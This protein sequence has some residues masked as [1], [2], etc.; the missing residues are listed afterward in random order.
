MIETLQDTVKMDPTDVMC[1]RCRAVEG[2]ACTNAKG[3]PTSRSHSERVEFRDY[4]V[5]KATGDGKTARWWRWK[6]RNEGPS[7]PT[8]KCGTDAGYA[9]HIRLKEDACE[10]CLVAHRDKVRV[11][12]RERRARIR[13]EQ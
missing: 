3:K 13:A 11:A 1:P 6:L 5:G 2:D 10:P 9:R 8:L 7:R 4:L 12:Q